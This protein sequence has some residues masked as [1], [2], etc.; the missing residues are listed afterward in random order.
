MNIVV[1]KHKESDPF[2]QSDR[3]NPI[4]GGKG[5]ANRSIGKSYRDNYGEIDWHRDKTKDRFGQPLIQGN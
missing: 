4:G 5:D 1:K 3:L 2:A